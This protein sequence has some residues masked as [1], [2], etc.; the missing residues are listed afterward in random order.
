MRFKEGKEDVEDDPRCGRPATSRTE[1]NVEFVRQKL[2]GDRRLNDCKCVGHELQEGV[3][4][5]YERSGDEEDL[6][7]SS[8]DVAERGAERAAW[9]VES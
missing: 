2:H 6:C 7:G 9:A 1:E 5:H 4:N 8:S 3:N